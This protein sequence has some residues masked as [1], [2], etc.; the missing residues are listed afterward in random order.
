M[1]EQ[2]NP[3]RLKALSKEDTKAGRK[4]R[5]GEYLKP[6]G[7]EGKAFIVFNG[8]TRGDNWNRPDDAPWTHMKTRTPKG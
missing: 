1:A 5:Q 4:L 3:Q 8:S 6:H 2:S 7:K